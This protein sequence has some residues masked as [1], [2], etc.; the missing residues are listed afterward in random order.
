MPGAQVAGISDPDPGVVAA[1]SERLDCSGDIDFRALC[2]KTKPDFVFALGRHSDM[3]EQARFLIEE[4]IAFALEKY[5]RLRDMRTP[6]N[7]IRPLRPET[8][9]KP[10]AR[11]AMGRTTP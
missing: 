7:V 3:V 1:L 11:Y 4:G 6:S 9:A 5:M 10:S 2:R 8:L